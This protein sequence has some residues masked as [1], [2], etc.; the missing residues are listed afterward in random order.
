MLPNA[1]VMQ[2]LAEDRRIKKIVVSAGS[3]LRQAMQRLTDQGRQS[4]GADDPGGNHSNM[5][6]ALLACNRRRGND[7]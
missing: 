5:P 2:C 4:L 7:D 1:P 6:Q 3:F